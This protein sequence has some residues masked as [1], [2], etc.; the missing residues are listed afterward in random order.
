MTHPINFILIPLSKKNATLRK[1]QTTIAIDDSQVFNRKSKIEN[2]KSY[3]R[4][5]ILTPSLK[6]AMVAITAI[7]K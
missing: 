3:Y 1:L 6:W 2:R 4:L 5:A 7:E